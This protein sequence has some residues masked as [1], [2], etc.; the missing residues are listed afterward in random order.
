MEAGGAYADDIGK[1]RM[2]ARLGCALGFGGSLGLG[3]GGLLGLGGC[4]R[5]C[6][7]AERVWCCSG[8]LRA[9]LRFT[10]GSKQSWIQRREWVNI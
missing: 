10:S 2:R 7:L 9:R 5:H 1:G 3:G 6:V 8:L 4:G